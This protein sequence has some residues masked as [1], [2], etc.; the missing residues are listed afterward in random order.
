[1][2]LTVSKPNNVLVLDGNSLATYID[3][4][5]GVLSLRDINGRSATVISELEK[6][7]IIVQGVV[8]G[9]LLNR[10]KIEAS[11]TIFI[12]EFYQY[13]LVTLLINEGIIITEGTLNII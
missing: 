3:S 7:D 13:N 1:M 5:T 8:S 12:P 2:A 4:Q 9:V 10:E 6:G 11:E